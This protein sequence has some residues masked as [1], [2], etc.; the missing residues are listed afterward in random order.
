MAE[1]TM[2]EEGR[3]QLSQLEQQSQGPPPVTH[4][5]GWS[6][7]SPLWYK[8]AMHSEPLPSQRRRE[9]Q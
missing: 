8:S 4:Q 7:K 9:V 1:K 6:N 3:A 2:L 5:V